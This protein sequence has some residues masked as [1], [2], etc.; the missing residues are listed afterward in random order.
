SFS[1]AEETRCRLQAKN[2]C[3]LCDG[4]SGGTKGGAGSI[5]SSG[6]PGKH[7]RD[8]QLH[9]LLIHFCA[10]CFGV[11][12]RSCTFCNTE[13]GHVQSAKRSWTVL[14]SHR[15]GG[16]VGITRFNPTVEKNSRPDRC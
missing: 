5:T 3:S 11:C 2:L 6:V 8:Q 9:L 4:T 15:C 13:V 14:R 12:R 16:I 7:A 1:P 10:H